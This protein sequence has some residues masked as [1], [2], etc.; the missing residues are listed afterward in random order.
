MSD[1]INGRTPEE[2]MIRIECWIN[3]W[4]K[5]CRAEMCGEC[6]LRIPGYKT[7][8]AIIDLYEYAK[9]LEER[10]RAE[11]EEPYKNDIWDCYRCTACGHKGINKTKFCSNC[12]AKMEGSI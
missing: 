6:E 11:W 1:M 10:R 8:Q 2:I 4:Q 5:Q 9:Q 3:F 12:G 7:E